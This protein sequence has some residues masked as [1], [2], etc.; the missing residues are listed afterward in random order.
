MSKPTL[1]LTHNYLT[2]RGAFQPTIHEVVEVTMQTISGD[3]PH[4][5]K[6]SITLSELITLTSHLRKNIKLYDGTIVPCNA[7]SIAL[8][9][10]GVSKDASMNKVRRALQPAY[11][12]L[13][14]K[15]KRIA[16][17]QAEQAALDDGQSTEE[18]INYYESPP[19]LQVGLGTVEGMVKHFS[20][21]EESEL[22]AASINASEIG[23]ELQSNQLF[24]DI[25]KTLAI[26]Y[27]LGKV[28]IKLIK[29]AENRVDAINSLPINA[30][31]FGSED[32]ILYDNT[33]KN[34]FKLM[35]NTQ[36]ARRTLFSFSRQKPK[37]REYKSVDD[38]FIHHEIQRTNSKT[39]QGNIEQYLM[40]MI[41]YTTTEPLTLSKEA[42]RAFDAYLEYNANLAETVSHQLPITK[43]SRKHKQWLA[44]KL[45]GN[46]TI[47]DGESV[48]SE[49]NYILAINTIEEL[50]ND[51]QDFEYELIKELYEQFAD[52]CKANIGNEE[53]LYLSIHELRKLGYITA[54]TNYIPK[55][56]ELIHLASM[57]DAEGVYTRCDDGICYELIIND[58][59]CGLSLLPFKK[60]EAESDAELKQRMTKSCDKGY[61]FYESDF[62][63]LSNVL[64]QYAAYSPFLFR[65]G[66]RSKT[67]LEGKTRWIVLDVDNST[68]TDKEA[69]LLLSDINHHIARTSDASNPFKFRILLELDMQIDISADNWK[70]FI[71]SVNNELG[72]ESD[73]LS[74][75]QIY[76]SYAANE[77]LSVIDSS[78][79]SAK[80]HVINASQRKRVERPTNLPKKQKEA[81]LNDKRET[82][83]YAYEAADGEGSRSLIKAA[84]H[85]KDLGADID[86]IIYLIEDINNYWTVPLNNDR[87][88][89]TIISQILRWK[90]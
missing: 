26:G 15:R 60:N 35:F 28:P 65:N 6:L 75:A 2:E 82:F 40:E 1:E 51:L 50:A 11:D 88:Q 74:K 59:K 89:Q 36:L 34:K 55:V 32:G 43:L 52:Y 31:M 69:H 58:N 9:A 83:A 80:Q 27:D 14:T 73:I 49:E 41:E 86:Y 25:I 21:L 78:P 29:A 24:L 37:P 44:L 18:W 19:A 20:M 22:G 57:Y 56:D 67:N 47:L 63:S 79:L 10:S 54:T 33:I 62:A 61:Q 17:E 87:L 71:E 12:L 45:S 85:A 39:A 66:K 53:K 42:Q 72:I 48:I 4:H 90:Q 8:A 23:S 77:V 30:L 5:L 16:R 81:A 13:H 3:I 38:I 76:F 70:Y 84:Y 46:Y 7:I 64:T 68:I